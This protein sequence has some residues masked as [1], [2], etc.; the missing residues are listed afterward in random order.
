MLLNWIASSNFECETMRTFNWLREHLWNLRNLVLT[1]TLIACHQIFLP[2]VQCL[3]YAQTFNRLSCQWSSS[4]TLGTIFGECAFT[5]QNWR[6]ESCPSYLWTWE[7]V[8]ILDCLQG[9]HIRDT[10]GNISLPVLPEEPP[11]LVSQPTYDV[12]ETA[13]IYLRTVRAWYSILFL[14]CYGVIL[15]RPFQSCS[16]KNTWLSCKSKIKL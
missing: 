6:L 4:T 8:C 11:I 15:I 12:E 5:S 10:P 7:T 3:G 9:N 14:K 2:S 16:T 13:G 1:G